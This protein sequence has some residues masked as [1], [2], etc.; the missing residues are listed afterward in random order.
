FFVLIPLVLIVGR[1]WKALAATLT[2]VA[3]WA[4]LSVAAFGLEPWFGFIRGLPLARGMILENQKDYWLSKMHTVFSAVRTV[5]GDM[6]TAYAVQTIV[7]IVAVLALIYIWNRRKL[8]LA[9]RGSSLCAAILLASPYSFEYDLVLLAIPI[10]LLAKEGIENGFLSFEKFFLFVL[11][12][13]PLFVRDYGG[14]Y[15]LPLTPLLLIGLMIL[16]WRRMK[17]CSS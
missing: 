12:V 7:A 3:V 11:W 9:I 15:V 4:G 6:Q 2:G 17:Q 13:S 10:A 1:Y 16:C 5:G 8:S 14:T